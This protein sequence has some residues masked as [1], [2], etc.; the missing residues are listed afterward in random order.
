MGNPKTMSQKPDCGPEINEYQDKARAEAREPT[1]WFWI[2][3]GSA[4]LAPALPLEA[5]APKPL[6]PAALKQLRANAEANARS[7]AADE[8][9]IISAYEC[10]AK[11]KK[12]V[13]L[14]SNFFDE[15]Y[16]VGKPKVDLEKF[17]TKFVASGIQ[18]L[19]K[20]RNQVWVQEAEQKYHVHF[21][22]REKAQG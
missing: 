16:F 12:K 21:F 14:E 4:A 2:Y 9:K 10:P 5:P 19:L 1:G 18:M 8:I 17:E 3:I 15:P 13:D 6:T 20:I 22:C 11:C 7:K